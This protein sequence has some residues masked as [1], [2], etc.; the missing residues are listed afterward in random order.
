MTPTPG[1]IEQEYLGDYH[2]EKNTFYSV[3]QDNIDLKRDVEI[4]K[5]TTGFK[6]KCD[7]NKSVDNILNVVNSVEKSP[8]I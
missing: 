8:F 7:V 4:A 5:K 6:R 1:Q 3:K 2:N